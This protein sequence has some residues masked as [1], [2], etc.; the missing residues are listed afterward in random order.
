MRLLDCKEE[1][2][3]RLAVGAPGITDSLCAACAEH[4]ERLQAYLG[5]LDIDY[6]ADP[7]IVRGFDYYTRTV[8]EIIA[9]E[10]GAQSAV[11]G[12]GRYDGL[13]AEVGGPDT[14]AV[15]FGMGME[16]LLLLM[17]KR[18]VAAP[19]PGLLDLFIVSHGDA[20]RTAAMK[21]AVQ[22]RDQGIR[23]DLDHAGRSLKAQFKY[24]DKLGCR[25][26][27]VIGEDELAEG[28]ATLRDMRDGG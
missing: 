28:R 7:F 8:F 27:A 23:C 24:A 15:G 2:C 17:E 18:G 12:G 22:L 21:L 20:A 13:I 26:V 19:D 6:E 3:R 1:G 14:P 5:A 4:F 9:D 25:F 11:C 16:R 10:I